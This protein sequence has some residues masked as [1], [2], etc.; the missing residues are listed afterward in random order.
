MTDHR[1]FSSTFVREGCDLADKQA[2]A[3]YGEHVPQISKFRRG[4]RCSQLPAAVTEMH[5]SA[6]LPARGLPTLPPSF[7]HL[8]YIIGQTGFREQSFPSARAEEDRRP[9]GIEDGALRSRGVDQ[10]AVL[11]GLM[12]CKAALVL[13]RTRTWVN[14]DRWLTGDRTK[15][16]FDETHQQ[17]LARCVAPVPRIVA[18]GS[19]I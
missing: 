5:V 14:H 3:M 19:A 1:L 9:Y 2:Q 4:H 16:I 10:Q 11:S 7:P 17:I 18:D 13:V 12:V 8:P 15:A 6:V